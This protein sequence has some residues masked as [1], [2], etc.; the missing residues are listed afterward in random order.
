MK[1]GKGKK[2]K[3]SRK[4]AFPPIIFVK[5]KKSSPF[6]LSSLS[7]FCCRWVGVGD[8]NLKF[9]HGRK[10]HRRR[11][12]K[13]PYFWA[14]RQIGSPPPF[15]IM[16]KKSTIFA[17]ETKNHLNGVRRATLRLLPGRAG[18]G[19]GKFPKRPSCSVQADFPCSLPK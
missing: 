5:K 12:R 7:Y 11:P 8:P 19:S 13:R 1:G 2:A 10:K 18:E 9:R 15:R 16:R 14:S 17:G 3:S 4:T 6:F